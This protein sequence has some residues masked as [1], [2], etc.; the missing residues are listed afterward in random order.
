MT[1]QKRKPVARQ[2]RRS[3][4][5]YSN[6]NF[7]TLV[8]KESEQRRRPVQAIKGEIKPLNDKQRAYDA[9]MKSSD[10]VFGIGPAGTGKTWF[11]VVRAAQALRDGEIEKIVLTRPAVEAG[12]TMGFLPGELEEKFEPYIRPVRDALEEALGSS[13]VE[14][15]LKNGKI[16]ARPLAYLRGASI[17]NAWLIADEMQNAT[18]PQFKMLLT[19]IG[20]SSKFII[21]GDPRQSDLPAGKSGLL[22]AVRRSKGFAEVSLVEFGHDD[23]VRSGLCQKFARAYDTPEN[24]CYNAVC[25]ETDSGLHRTLTYGVNT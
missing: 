14:M 22:D 6:D 16:E 8:K 21:N 19:R 5:D 18:I 24:D 1:S 15:Y 4:R 10:V 12:E 17:K 20:E 9:A 25:N 3:K 7:L 2:D 23:I 11:S 13:H